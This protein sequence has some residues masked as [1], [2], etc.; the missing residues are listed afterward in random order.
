LPLL[1]S[2]ASQ[3]F[4]AWPYQKYHIVFYGNNTIYG[5]PDALE[6]ESSPTYHPIMACNLLGVWE[7]STGFMTVPATRFEQPMFWCF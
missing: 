3:Y 6:A 2:K 7:E 5:A 4:I 1:A